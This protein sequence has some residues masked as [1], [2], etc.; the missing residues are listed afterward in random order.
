MSELRELAR[1]LSGLRWEDVPEEVRKTVRLLLLDNLGAALG[2]A[3][4]PLPG[5]V[6]GVY[7]PLAGEKGR[8]S[9]WGRGTKAPLTT[10]VFL[11]ALAGDALGLDDLHT[12]SKTHIGVVVIPAAWGLAEQL[13]CSGEELLLA[14]VC[15]YEAMAR[16]GK[17]LGVS[18]H[19]K[20][21]W[22]ATATAGT[23]G[24]AAACGKLLGLA[25]EEMTSALGLAGS[26]S[27]GVWAFLGDGTNSKSLNPAR[28]A[29][30]GCEA[31]LLAKAG[32]TGPE[33]ILTAPDGGLLTAMTR[34]GDAAQA[35]KD[36]GTVWEILQMDNRPYPCARS[37][38]GAVD[39]ALAL[40]RE[41]RLSPGE[42]DWVWV[43]TYQ[44]GFQQCG[45]GEGSL[46]PRT[47]AQAKFSTP[48]CVACGLLYGEGASPFHT[49]MD[50]KAGGPGIFASDCGN[51]G[52]RADGGLSQALGEPGH[53]GM[54][55][56]AAAFGGGHRCFR[57]CGQSADPGAGAGQGPGAYPGKSRG[58]GGGH[59]RGHSGFG[60][61]GHPAGA[62]TLVGPFI[63]YIC[64]LGA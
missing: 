51:G 61:G 30:S 42:I 54:P 56:R 7:L 49:G 16:V 19:R 36:L 39:G 53:G 62:V 27:F 44:V 63:Q 23:F 46:R 31:A 22:H 57:E 21:G 33:H 1:F 3:K 5:A 29:V 8:V 17:A 64:P 18:S 43:D 2:A 60:S 40:R 15:G 9:L 4:A 38:H 25:E 26:Q 12:G 47:P 50:L 45:C 28:A 55:G 35:A 13:G 32:M 52:Q 41:H 34:E 58:E 48:Y 59:C 11:N 6:A 14:V 10:A 37:T 20:Q 24:A